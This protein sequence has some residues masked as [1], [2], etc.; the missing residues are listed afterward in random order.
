L[1]DI[2]YKHIIICRNSVYHEI[3]KAENYIETEPFIKIVPLK[4]IKFEE[5]YLK[6]EERLVME[7]QLP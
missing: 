3:N 6:S 5:N 4:D 2:E 1:K 7:I